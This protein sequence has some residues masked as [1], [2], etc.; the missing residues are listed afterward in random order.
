MLVTIIGAGLAGSEAAAL[1][2]EK[3][4]KVRLYEMRP[5]RQTPAHESGLFAELVCSNSLRSDKPDTAPGLLKAELRRLGSPILRMAD[6]YA[7]PAGGALA[8]DR[9]LFAQ[10]VTSL[11]SQYENIEVIRE[12]CTEIP[13]GPVIIAA[14]PLCSQ[15]LAESIA[16]LLGSKSLFF[17]DAAAPIVTYESLDLTKIFRAGRYGKGDDYLNCPLTKEEY[18]R[19]VQELT[20]AEIAP[21]HAFEKNRV[22]EGCMPVEVMAARGFES[23]A[24]GPLKPVGL[25]P[26][27][28]S[29]PYAV[30]QLRQD[31][32]EGRLYNLVGFQ[33]GLKFGEQ[34]RVFSL[35]PGLEQADFARYGVM[36]RNT[37]IASPGHLDYNFQLKARPGLFFAGQITGVEGYLESA[38]SGHLAARAMHAHLT[39]APLP[40]FTAT[41]AIGALGRYVAEYAGADFQPMHINFGIINPWEGSQRVKKRERYALIAA[42][43]LAYLETLCAQF[44]EN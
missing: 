31:D 25:R 43:S 17:F 4:H 3:G 13:E 35:I 5:Q 36:H 10:G 12:E 42:R 1:L 38:A 28:G 18:T 19:F 41:T 9:E 21:V 8:V 29:R 22:F 32:K 2:A 34:K 24:F 37:Y 44:G 14:G 27:D 26:P 20:A 30:V 40:D 15:P 33:T 6:Q 7:V 23:L 39:G 11:L 16:S